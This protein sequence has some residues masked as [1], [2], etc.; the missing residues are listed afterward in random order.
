MPVL[1]FEDGKMAPSQPYTEDKTMN[2][3]TYDRLLSRKE[4]AEAL[5][6]E[7]FTIAESTLATMATIGGGPPYRKF[8]R[9]VKYEWN[10][11]LHWAKSRLSDLFYNSS[12]ARSKTGF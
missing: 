1:S 4:I 9:Y 2:T 6:K 11:A 5:T 10:D 7:G 8:G 12:E 3:V